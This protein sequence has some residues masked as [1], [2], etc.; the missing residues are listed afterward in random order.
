MKKVFLIILCILVV[1]IPTYIAIASYGSSHKEPVTIDNVDKLEI[2]DLNGVKSEVVKGEDEGF[3]EF[4]VSASDNA[5]KILALPDPL[6]DN[7]YF[8]VTYHSFGK[9]NTYSY[10]FSKQS[11]DAYFVDPNGMAYHML[12]DDAEKFLKTEYAHCI[13]D[14]STAPTMMLDGAIMNATSGKWEFKGYGGDF[15]DSEVSRGTNAVVETYGTPIITFNVDPDSIAVVLKKGDE[16]IFDGY[17]SDLAYQ[18]LRG[19]DTSAHIVA[20]W[21]EGADR[22]YRGE[23][24]YDLEIIFKEPPVFFISSNKARR[25]CLNCRC[26]FNVIFAAASSAI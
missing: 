5:E 20:T 16:V 2:V 18:D 10:Y 23:I 1:F 24:N 11:T 26:I 22:N 7:P 8:L 4:M 17:Y 13:F 25:L 15:Y 19:N 14:Y 6:L 12:R 21:Y 3:I 9:E